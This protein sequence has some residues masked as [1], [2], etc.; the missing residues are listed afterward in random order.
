MKKCTGDERGR[1]SRRKVTKSIDVLQT[2]VSN[3]T[4]NITI[5]KCL[6]TL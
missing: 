4:P 2:G 6:S 1:C 3:K 5:I